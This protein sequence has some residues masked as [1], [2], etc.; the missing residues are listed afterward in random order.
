MN[1]VVVGINH[2]KCPVGIRERINFPNIPGALE[3]AKSQAGVEE[4]VVLATCNRSE[5]YVLTKNENQAVSA[6]K[7][8]FYDQ[9]QIKNLDLKEYFYSY[10][11]Y[12]A[13]KHLFNVTAGLDSMIIGEPQITGQVKNAYELAGNEKTVSKIFHKLFQ[14]AFKANK[15]IRST[16]DIA[17]G[18]VSVSYAACEIAKKIL[19]PI[20]D[21]KVL[22]VGAG[23]MIRLAALQFK[24]AQVCDLFLCN[25]TPENIQDLLK[26]TQANSLSFVE[27]YDDLFKFDVVI[28]GTAS[29]D[30]LVTKE[31]LVAAMKQ[32]KGECLFVV[33][34]SVPRNVDPSAQALTNLFLYNIDDLKNV[35]EENKQKRE[36]E[37]KAADKIIEY[38][39]YLFLTWLDN[40]E[41]SEFMAKLSRKL[42]DVNEQ[43]FQAYLQKLKDD[44]L[45]T[46]KDDPKNVTPK[47]FIQNM[48]NSF[49][50]DKC[51]NEKIDYIERIE[52]I[53]NL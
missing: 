44:N 42:D 36:Q 37:L 31:H 15:E 21:K 46:L 24:S 17:S 49:K 29:Q 14:T 48:A 43:D 7:K 16:T 3:I 40:L 2:N 28:I 32:R 51:A 25:R 41:V 52:K 20:Q 19:D 13:V 35:I 8:I 5:I 6:I 23:E 50:Q 1:I 12:E 47:M 10:F 33:D 9:H 34:I 4:A 22:L 26:E 18:A 38:H 45:Y 11:D 53:L 39:K 27:L 30:Y